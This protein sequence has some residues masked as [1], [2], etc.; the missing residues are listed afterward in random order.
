VEARAMS[1]LPVPLSPV[2]NTV[3]GV[4]AT[5]SIIE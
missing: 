3:L 2:I 5:R 1:S 4:F